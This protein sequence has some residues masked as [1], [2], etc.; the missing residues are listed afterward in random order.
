MAILMKF[1]NFGLIMPINYLF[2]QE[3]T[4]ILLFKKK[5]RMDSKIKEKL[6]IVIM[7]DE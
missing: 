6:L 5:Q 1:A 4:Q 2:L 7:G 3:E